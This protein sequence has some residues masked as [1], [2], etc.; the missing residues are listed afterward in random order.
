MYYG[1]LAAILILR[2]TGVPAPMRDQYPAPLLQGLGSGA[3]GPR[4]DPGLLSVPAGLQPQRG[5]GDPGGEEGSQLPRLVLD[6]P[7]AR[8]GPV[9]G[10]NMRL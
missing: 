7:G 2:P 8:D 1:G 3:A 4:T 10:R 5:G 6:D 9:Q